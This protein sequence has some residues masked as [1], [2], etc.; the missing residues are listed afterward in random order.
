MHADTF[1]YELRINGL[2]FVVDT[3]ISTYNKNCRRQYERSTIAHNTVSVDNK[4]SS[5]VWGGFRV[6]KRCKVTIELE[7]N[8][9][10][11]ASHKAYKNRWQRIFR[12]T[13]KEFAIEDYYD[14]DAVSYIHLPANADESRIRIEGATH[15]DV[16]QGKY[17]TAYNTLLDCK[18]IKIKFNG[19]LRYSIQ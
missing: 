3:G 5:R 2:P 13:N 19:K 9:I 4:D 17:A 14:G 10:I 16:E 6:G 11:K 15:I 18:I 8:T 12:I 1:S 7:S